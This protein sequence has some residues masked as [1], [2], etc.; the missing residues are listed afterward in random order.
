MGGVALV[1]FVRQERKVA[2]PILPLFLFRNREFSVA[3]TTSFITGFGLFLPFAY[4][5][6]VLQSFC[7]NPPMGFGLVV[8]GFGVD[9]CPLI[10]DNNR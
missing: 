5:P 10:W 4:F 1:W 7:L 8:G 3:N 2:S 9:K 6:V